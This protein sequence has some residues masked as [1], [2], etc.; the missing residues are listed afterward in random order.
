MKKIMKIY[1]VKVNGKTYEV[2]LESV[3]EVAS[4]ETVVEQKVETPKK[5]TS[6]K[7]ANSNVEGLDV[8]SP[9]QGNVID[10]KVKVGDKV[11][12]GDVLLLIEAMKLENEVNAPCDGEVVEVIAAKGQT[13]TTKQLLLKIK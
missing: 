10:V 11:K 2:Q 1:K 4:T 7:V 3:E 13:V 8:L 6:K 9:I 5:A 12:K